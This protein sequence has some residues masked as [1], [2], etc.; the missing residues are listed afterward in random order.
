M[1]SLFDREI[2]N[3]GELEQDRAELARLAQRLERCQE[4]APYLVG[5]LRGDVLEAD[6]VLAR[7]GGGLPQV[8]R[9]HPH[10]GGMLGEQ[11][12]RLDVDGE[13][14]RCPCRPGR[15]GPLAGQ[16]IVGGVH[17]DQR[18]WLA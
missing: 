4:P 6:A 5:H 18:D 17:L 16:R 1:Y 12:E 9:E 13:P 15:R 11:A 7:L 10:R 3:Q 14:V 8:S 2:G